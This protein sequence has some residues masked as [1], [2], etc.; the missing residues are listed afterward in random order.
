MVFISSKLLPDDQQ[1]HRRLQARYTGPYWVLEKVHDNA[2]R[3]EGLPEGMP[4]VVNVSML[5]RFRPSPDRFRSRHQASSAVVPTEEGD[6]LNYD[7]KAIIGHKGEGRTRK[8]QIQWT[9]DERS[10]WLRPNHLKGC[11]RLLR[12]YQANHGLTLT[13]WPE[14]SELSDL[15]TDEGPEERTPNAALP[16]TGINDSSLPRETSLEGT[17]SQQ[18]PRTSQHPIPTAPIPSSSTYLQSPSATNPSIPT[19]SVASPPRRSKRLA[20]QATLALPND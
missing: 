5:R 20:S 2:Y 9:G 18:T 7:V 8:Y 13:Y 15:E 10:S 19:P 17:A 14:E 11:A 3:L 4:S 16:Q 6:N 1:P 12:D